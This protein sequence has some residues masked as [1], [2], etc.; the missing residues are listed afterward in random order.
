MPMIRVGSLESIDNVGQFGP[1]VVLA[2]LRT[3][4]R[5]GNP[6][7]FAHVLQLR[8]DLLVFKL[9]ALS[10]LL[11]IPEARVGV[12]VGGYRLAGAWTKAR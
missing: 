1:H 8:T 3:R 10:G 12:A 11:C 6:G 4:E 9:V 5:F 2:G 7:T